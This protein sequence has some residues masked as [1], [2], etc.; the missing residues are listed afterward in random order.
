VSA[1]KI[2]AHADEKLI[3][4]VSRAR[5]GDQGALEKIVRAT[6]DDVYHLA[7]RMTGNAADA[8][9]ACQ[10]VFIKVITHLGEFRGE[11][12]LRT[13]IHRIAVNHLLDRKKSRLEQMSMTFD[14]FGQDLLDG[15]S[16]EPHPD[17]A[18]ADEVKRGCTLAMLTCL[19]REH[20]LAVVLTEVFDLPIEYAAELS[21]VNQAT[22]R[23]RI[24]RARRALE[25][26]TQQYCGLVSASAR[27]HCARRVDRAL[28]LGRVS[29]RDQ[30]AREHLAKATL[31]MNELHSTAAL[32]RQQPEDRAP[33]RVAKIV[34]E[35]IAKRTT[36][37]S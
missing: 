6:Q 36:L 5:S 4:E 24:S 26:F 30:A 18:L 29:K 25:T 19:D 23:Q 10:E 21:G 28:E 37:L 31:E 14:S 3:E 32:I 1:V 8:E 17:D 27:C 11:A 2:E 22:Y 13:W 20:R 9:D 16:A 15:L 12:G 34:G 7:L 35:L 33:E